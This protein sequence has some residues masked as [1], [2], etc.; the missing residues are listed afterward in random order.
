MKC[1]N[2]VSF[3]AYQPLV[4]T[5]VKDFIDA[6]FRGSLTIPHMCTFALVRCALRFIKKAR[7]RACCRK[8]LLEILLNLVSFSG[9]DI[10]CIKMLHHLENVLLNGLH[11][12]S[13]DQQKNAVLPSPL[14]KWPGW[15]IND[16]NLV[17]F[18]LFVWLFV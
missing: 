1:A 10:D 6:V 12:L 8:Q 7:H 4:T 15:I 17:S 2:D 11:N 3:S 16:S 18:C 5:D 9:I 14:S 13:K